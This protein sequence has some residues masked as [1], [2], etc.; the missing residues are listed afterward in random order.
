[1]R[2]SFVSILN[3]HK[4]QVLEKL[5]KLLK[6]LSRWCIIIWIYANLLSLGCFLSYAFR[7]A[8]FH[9]QSIWTS[10]VVGEMR[11]LIKTEINSV[12]FNI[13]K[14]KWNRPLKV[15]LT[16]AIFLF[17]WPHSNCM[18]IFGGKIKYHKFSLFFVVLL[19]IVKAFPSEGLS[20]TKKENSSSSSTHLRCCKRLNEI[21]AKWNK[22]GVVVDEAS[23]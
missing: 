10:N 6:E 22:K 19:P 2:I 15:L 8:V 7:F 11:L 9:P 18:I 21:K 13:K 16:L 4:I 5:E 12:L 1:M 17:T 3:I 23:W 14:I 20:S